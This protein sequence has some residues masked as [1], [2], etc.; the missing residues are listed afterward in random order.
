M[1]S[2][3]IQPKKLNQLPSAKIK[4][5]LG[6]KRKLSR[7]NDP[8]ADAAHA[9]FQEIKP[10]ILMRDKHTCQACGFV[11]YQ[12]KGAPGGFL[13]VH[14]ID[15]DHHNNAANNLITLC[16]FCHQVFTL[17]RR[18]DRFGGRLIWLPEISQEHLNILCHAMFA[19][20]YMHND[21]D[22]KLSPE[23]SEMTAKVYDLHSSLTDLCTQRLHAVYSDIQF[24]ENIET[25]YVALSGLTDKEYAR[26][27]LFLGGVRI[28]PDFVHFEEHV[29]FWTRNVWIKGVPPG[30][31]MAIINQLDQ[32]IKR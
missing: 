25:L 26:R 30:N 13:E 3:L 27:H 21:E 5:E 15:D 1:N 20:M 23:Q 14:H 32:A 16:P 17:G 28:L 22:I 9:V 8:D 18:G 2:T 24:F 19:I 31:W 7:Q 12:D 10:K 6:V 4:L 11:S 29:A